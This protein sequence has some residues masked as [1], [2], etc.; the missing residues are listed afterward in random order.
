[1][2]EEE[3]NAFDNASVDE[4]VSEKKKTPK[5][6][7]K[8]VT[9]KPPETI[10]ERIRYTEFVKMCVRRV[11]DAQKL[12]IQM[13]LRVKQMERDGRIAKNIAED[14]FNEAHK[15]EMQTEAEYVLIVWNAVKDYPIVR[16]WASKVKG[17]GPKLSGLLVALIGHPSRF[18]TTSKLWAYAGLKVVNGASVR[19]EFGKSRGCNEELLM[20]AWKIGKSFVKQKDSAYGQYYVRE[21]ARLLQRTLNGWQQTVSWDKDGNVV[22]PHVV[23]H[24]PRAI[25]HKPVVG[26]PWLPYALPAGMNV[27]FV[28]KN[29]V[30]VDECYREDGIT[31]EN[32]NRPDPEIVRKKL[33]KTQRG[34]NGVKSAE[35]IANDKLWSPQWSLGRI[36]NMAVRKT[37]KLFLSNLY[38]VWCKMEGIPTRPPYPIEHL[39][40]VT[41]IDP[42]EML[43]P[44]KVNKDMKKAG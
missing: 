44:G 16:D 14:L 26:G 35:E 21:K 5:K 23:R 17:I 40:H 32:C 22:E 34:K 19:R 6:D 4:P 33:K 38:E 10:E 15:L 24:A 2:N 27:R 30:W 36:D 37:A 29:G 20:T 42:W 28:Q 41:K 9:Y 39:G 31:I 11:Y 25:W 43:D 3:T 1:M 12:R 13:T 8:R 7:L 18:A